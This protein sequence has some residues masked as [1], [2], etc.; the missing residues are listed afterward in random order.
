ME[1]PFVDIEQH[2]PWRQ[3]MKPRRL[4]E[5]ICSC[6]Y[7]RICFRGSAVEGI[8]LGTSNDW[9]LRRRN[10]DIPRH[11]RCSRLL[12]SCAAWRAT[13]NGYAPTKT[14]RNEAQ[15]TPIVLQWEISQVDQPSN[16]HVPLQ[17]LA[18][19]LWW[20]RLGLEVR[21]CLCL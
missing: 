15:E 2:R 1:R 9:Q 20:P 4:R 3:R 8:K 11:D 12:R 16:Q 21:G 18:P 17:P 10:H 6:G 5:I 19:W 13:I 14:C 7:F